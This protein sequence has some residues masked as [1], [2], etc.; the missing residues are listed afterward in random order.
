MQVHAEELRDPVGRGAIGSARNAQDDTEE[1]LVT[2]GI[3]C[4]RT[5]DAARLGGVGVDAH[6]L[7]T[8]REIAFRD[9]CLAGSVFRMQNTSAMSEN[10]MRMSSGNLSYLVS[11]FLSSSGY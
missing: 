8:C 10:D 7:G 11:Q 1:K 5:S 9:R 2:S 4:T 6:M 3:P